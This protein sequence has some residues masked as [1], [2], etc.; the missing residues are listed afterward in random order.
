MSKKYNDKIV[1]QLK[2]ESYSRFIEVYSNSQVLEAYL[3][4]S[5]CTY[6]LYKSYLK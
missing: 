5:T 3:S 1:N 4:D 2:I 6:S